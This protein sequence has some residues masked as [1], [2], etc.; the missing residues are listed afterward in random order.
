M[1]VL[2]CLTKGYLHFQFNIHLTNLSTFFDAFA[3]DLVISL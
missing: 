1:Q 3:E 2:H